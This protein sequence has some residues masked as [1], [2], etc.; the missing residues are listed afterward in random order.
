MT[1]KHGKTYTFRRFSNSR[2]VSQVSSLPFAFL[3]AFVHFTFRGFRFFL[4]DLLHFDVQN[5]KVFVFLQ[6]I[7]QNRTKII[8]KYTGD[9]M[10]YD[11]E[12]VPYSR[13]LQT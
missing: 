5:R 11:M 10:T 6:N 12:G 7:L 8:I 13:F 4:K 9:H 3:Y 1:H 2:E